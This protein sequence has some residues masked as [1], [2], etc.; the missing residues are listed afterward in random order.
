MLSGSSRW[1]WKKIK[2][3]K[4]Q[5]AQKIDGLGT[6]ELSLI[7]SAVRQVWQRGRSRALVIKRC[8][9]KDGFLRCESC[10]K[11]T[12]QIKVD[13]ID[14]VGK[15]GGPDYI[16]RMFVPSSQ[17]QGLCKKCHDAKTRAEK[18]AAKELVL[19][20]APGMKPDPS[21]KGKVVQLEYLKPDHTK[22]TTVGAGGGGGSG[23]PRRN[24]YRHGA[25][26]GRVRKATRKRKPDFTD[27]F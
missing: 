27:E 23:R 3:A 24:P 8:T 26:D 6:R 7:H 17:L 4:R 25:K 2:V 14:A 21:F 9:G 10:Q 16:Q 22:V 11:K 20:V 19:W 5:K 15:V 1:Y 12:P 13:H 18:A